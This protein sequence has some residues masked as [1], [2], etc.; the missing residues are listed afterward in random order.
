M[1]VNNEEQLKFLQEENLL[2]REQVRRMEKEKETA[3]TNSQRRTEFMQIINMITYSTDLDSIPLSV[4]GAVEELTGYTENDFLNGTVQ[5]EKIIHPEDLPQF[6][7][8]IHKILEGQNLNEAMEYRIIS[9]EGQTYWLND[10]ALLV[11]D[12]ENTPTAI[13]GLVMDVTR[14]KMA[15]DDFREREAHLDSILNSVQDVIWSVTPDTFELL[16]INPAAEKVYGYT[17]EEIY[18]LANSNDPRLD[19]HNEMLLENF[20][21]LLQCGWFEK[22]YRIPQPSGG[23]RWLRRRAHF[24]RDAHGV[25]ARIDGIDT[26][27]TARKH[28]EERLKYISLH[29][30]LTGLYNRFYFENQMHLLEKVDTSAIGL[31]VCDIDGLKMVNDNMGHEAGDQLLILCARMLQ[32]SFPED[33]MISRIGGD[34]FTVLLKDVTLEK[35]QSYMADMKY[36]TTE[37]N[38]SHP[39]FPISMS[40]GHALKNTAKFSINDLFREADNRM[41]AQKPFNHAAFQKLWNQRNI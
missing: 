13:E 3:R 25:L 38:L 35:I 24:A 17:L 34:E 15:E 29:D 30:S 6:K 18:D 10:S 1:S 14:R 8:C 36:K 37:H 41:Y 26:D 7:A 39:Q 33:T 22:E 32:E 9:G 40:I 5:W 19:F 21:T 16:Y 20:A 2:L 12:Q 4:R 28:A 23:S 27:I 11:Q 31:I